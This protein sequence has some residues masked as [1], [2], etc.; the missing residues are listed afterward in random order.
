[1]S[2]HHLLP[3]PQQFKE[4]KDR[5]KDYELAGFPQCDVSMIEILKFFNRHAGIATIFCCE[6]HVKVKQV[7]YGSKKIT[8][9]RNS[10]YIQFALTEDGFEFITE[11]TEK[12]FH[13]LSHEAIQKLNY[14]QSQADLLKVSL[15]EYKNNLTTKD[16]E[17]IDGMFPSVYRFAHEAVLSFRSNIHFDEETDNDKVYL[18][19]SY[20]PKV[21][22]T[23]PIQTAND[24]RI[25]HKAIRE[26]IKIYGYEINPAVSANMVLLA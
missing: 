4:L 6:G 12:L 24:H 25:V 26:V 7:L 20:M 8:A 2:V 13:L 18:S 23:L 21:I 5:A 3:T 16:R 10:C 14:E 9:V 11:F 19:Y 22:L 15:F 17:K 1:M